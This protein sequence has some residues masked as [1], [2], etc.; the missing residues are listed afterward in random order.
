[1]STTCPGTPQRPDVA[2]EYTRAGDV[3]SSVR[4]P[5]PRRFTIEG[6]AEVFTIQTPA[7]V[8]GTPTPVDVREARTQLVAP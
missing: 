5:G 2:H 3:S 6:S 4:G 7:Y 8:Q 1:M